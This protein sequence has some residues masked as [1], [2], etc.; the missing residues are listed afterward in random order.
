MRNSAAV[1]EFRVYKVA[2]HDGAHYFYRAWIFRVMSEQS[3]F[4]DS[5]PS[6]RLPAAPAA[7]YS[8]RQKSRFAPIRRFDPDH[9]ELLDRPGMD[10][11]LLREEL[12]TLENCN[13]RLGGHDL[14]LRYVKRFVESTGTTSLN[15]LDLGTG[16]GDIPRAIAAWA[17]ERQLP[18]AITAVDGNSE[19]LQIAHKSC[20]SW[21]EIRLEQHDLRALPYVAGSFDLVLCSLV[22]HH[23]ASTEA[24]AV[25]QSIHTLA[26]RGYV[27]N[28]LRRN[29]LAI[30]STEL[31]VR[32]VS[33]S[34]VFRHDAAQS[35]RAAFTVEELRAMAER[36]GLNHFQIWQHH[37]VFR[38]VLEGRK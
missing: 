34:A 13:R 31:L 22:L 25:L 18:V 5:L 2:F 16:S 24:V 15:I 35:C 1:P 26:R 32:A 14:A 20:D 12:Q 21:P 19:I 27:V 3:D 33:R 9:P 38:M 37:A 11:E 30:W 10:R 29:W 36:A 23:F 8:R 6:E 7:F 28:D 4:N 17:R